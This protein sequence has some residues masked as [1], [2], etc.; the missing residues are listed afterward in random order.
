MEIKNVKLGATQVNKI[1]VGENLNWMYE[2]PDTTAP[3][4]T[5]YPNPADIN[6]THY[7]GQKVWLEVN[8]MCNTYYTLDGSTPT[9]SSTKFIDAFT[10]NETTTIK[11]FSVDLAGNVETVKTTVFDITGGLPATTISPAA[12]VQ[13]NIPITITLTT[14]E[15]GATIKYIVGTGTEQTYTG[16]FTVNQ[17][18]AGVGSVNITVKY[19]SIGANGT[20][21]QKTIT[22]NTSGAVPAK[23]VV[24]ATP[25]TN[26]VDLSWTATANTTAYTVYRSTAP[27]TLGT[28]L[29]QYLWNTIYTDN[30]AIAGTAYYYTVRSQNY[31]ANFTDSDQA[32]ATPTAAVSNNWRYLL[33]EGYGA[34]E[35]GQE[36]TTR[37]IEFQAWA[38]ATNVMQTLSSISWEVPNNSVVPAKTTIYDGNFTTTSNT[39]PFWWLATPNANIIVD[40][41]SQKNLTKLNWFGYSTGAAPRTNR[42]NVKASN[43]NNGTDWTT[44]WDNQTGQAGVQ[45]ILPNGYEK[46][47]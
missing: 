17:S 20:E 18:S 1:Y 19:W 16:P 46:V 41:G 11:Y 14:S 30:T 47:L 10:L 7:A 12:T 23:T 37:L 42:F 15:Q 25:G 34:A 39:Y 35:A 24:T 13:N 21:P 31:S 27:G 3:V 9:I 36:A 5:V 33:L 26:K 4:T 32:T 29:E 8:E 6:L 45:P 43:T 38:G 22:Y 44:I 2:A 40:F 28:M